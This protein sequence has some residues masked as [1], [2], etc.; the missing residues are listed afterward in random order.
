MLKAD[1]KSDP[2]NVW[3]LTS[4]GHRK[5]KHSLLGTF[6]SVIFSLFWMGLLSC[7]THPSPVIWSQ[8]L[9][10]KVTKGC[11]LPSAECDSGTGRVRNTCKKPPSRPAAVSERWWNVSLG[12]CE[13]H[14]KTEGEKS[15]DLSGICQ[16][17][18][19]FE[20]LLC[21]RD[22]TKE[23]SGVWVYFGSFFY[24]T[25]KSLVGP[26]AEQNQFASWRLRI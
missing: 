4:V 15:G 19:H 2:V 7:L 24:T 13:D 25:Q 18:A 9:T 8:A 11:N 23:N 12:E 17:D 20:H 3:R 14:A 21:W 10:G 6:L 5:K 1:R 22:A 26:A 16:V